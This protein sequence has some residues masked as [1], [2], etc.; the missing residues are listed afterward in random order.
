MSADGTD[1]PTPADA[2]EATLP[3]RDPPLPFHRKWWTYQRERFPFVAHGALIA[4]FSFCAV[5]LSRLLRGEPGWPAWPSLLVAFVTCFTFFLQLRIADEFKDHEED[6]RHRPYRPVQRGLVTLRELGVVFVIAGLLQFG[7]A[8]WLKPS[9]IW[10]LGVTWLYLAA[11]S[12]EFFVADWLRKRHVLY[13][14]SHMAIMPLVDLYA[15]STDWLVAGDN[16]PPPGLGWFLAASYFN[17][18]VIEIGRKIRSEA[19]E[20][21]GVETYSRLWGRGGATAAWCGAV[22]ATATLAAIVAW[23]LPARAW[24]IGALGL[25]VVGAIGIARGFLAAP[26]AGRGKRIENMAGLWTIVL[27]LSLGLLPRLIGGGAR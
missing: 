22:V 17:G 5:S 9:L 15:T 20:E 1:T 26:T 6:L 3:R 12:K 2:V 11:M 16:R 13:M 7:L 19:D 25:G 21:A 27:Y 8:L 24:V 18:I 23:R 4:S 10:L 14:V